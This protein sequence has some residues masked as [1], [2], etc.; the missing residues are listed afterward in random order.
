MEEM[1]NVILLN[2]EFGNE[3]KFEFLDLVSYEGE[4]YIVLLPADDDSEGTVVI[5]RVDDSDDR[6]EENYVSVEDEAVLNAVFGIFKTSSKMS[7]I[8]RIETVRLDIDSSK[9]D[10]FEGMY[11]KVYQNFSCV[12]S[13]SVCV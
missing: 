13:S 12:F 4:E 10:I 7:L 5:L 8:L 1:D 2:D 3:V 6:D 11:D 9:T